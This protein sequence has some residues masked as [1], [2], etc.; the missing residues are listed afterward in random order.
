[1][2][3]YFFMP[4]FPL[5]L[6]CGALAILAAAYVE[7]YLLFRRHAAPGATGSRLCFEMFRFFD[8][9]MFIYAVSFFRFQ[10]QL[11]KIVLQIAQLTFDK[12][13]R[14]EIS[15][16]S[17]IYLGFS[18]FFWCF[19]LHYGFQKLFT[20]KNNEAET[21]QRTYNQVRTLFLAEYDR[22]NPIT[23]ASATKEFL[24][25]MKRKLQFV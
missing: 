7:K 11:T 10:I 21:N 2:V 5:S 14:D 17:W 9:I 23:T 22:C 3:C 12:I 19:G 8:F 25:Y 6:L 24:R 13:F 16:Y 15:V 1:M 20:F 18:L 4:M